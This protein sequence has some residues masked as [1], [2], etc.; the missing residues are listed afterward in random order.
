MDETA[1]CMHLEEKVDFWYLSENFFSLIYMSIPS[2]SC[3]SDANRS[4]MRL[5]D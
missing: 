1:H 5:L 4:D 3:A 2:V